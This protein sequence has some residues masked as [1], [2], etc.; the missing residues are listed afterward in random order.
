MPSFKGQK[1]SRAELLV[2]YE[3]AQSSAQHH[4][5]LVWTVTNVLWALSFALF[6]FVVSLLDKERLMSLVPFRVLL[7]LV[8]FVGFSLPAYAWVFARQLARLRNSKYARCKTIERKLGLRNHSDV[9]HPKTFQQ[10]I[11]GAMVLSIGLLWLYL[12]AMLWWSAWPK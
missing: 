8:C 10:Q 1:A 6:G 12:A 4:D 11:Y 3:S 2:E 7:T 9:N 5:G